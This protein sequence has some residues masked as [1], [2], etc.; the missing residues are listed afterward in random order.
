VI[1]FG[2]RTQKGTKKVSCCRGQGHVMSR[3]Q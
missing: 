1:C 2:S 3:I